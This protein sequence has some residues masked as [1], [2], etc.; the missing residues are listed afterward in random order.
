MDTHATPLTTDF[1]NGQ[2]IVPSAG[3]S[4][5]FAS[6]FIDSPSA[7][8]MTRASTRKISP[9][10]NK[11]L[12]NLSSNYSEVKMSPF[13]IVP[14]LSGELIEEANYRA[15]NLPFVT[16]QLAILM[17]LTSLWQQRTIGSTIS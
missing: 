6:S 16:W 2:L 14:K 3:T 10:R 12:S 17:Q 5:I 13:L 7:H 8:Q 9:N 11:F 15:H 4:R 1:L